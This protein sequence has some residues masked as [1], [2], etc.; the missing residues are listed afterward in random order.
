MTHENGLLLLYEHL[1]Q[2]QSLGL[3]EIPPKPGNEI[4]GRRKVFKIPSI[5]ISK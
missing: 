3:T 2:V 4:M 1:R 5:S